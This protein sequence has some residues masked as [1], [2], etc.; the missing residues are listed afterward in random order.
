MARRAYGKRGYCHHVRL[1]T[2]TENGSSFNYEAFIGVDQPAKYGGGCS[3]RNIWLTVTKK[4][5]RR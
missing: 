4:E 2:Y 3:G 1:D 5:G